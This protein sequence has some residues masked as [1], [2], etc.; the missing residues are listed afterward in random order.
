M[1]ENWANLSFGSK[2]GIVVG[3]T[4]VLCLFSFLLFNGIFVNTVDNYQVAYRY[5]LI[6]PNRGKIVILTNPDGS[7]RRGW[8]ITAPFVTKVHTVDLRPMQVQMNANSRVLNAKLIQF[9]P[10]GLKLFLDWHGRNNYEGPGS[11]GTTG[12]GV[13]ST[14]FSEILRSYAYDGKHYPFLTI[15]RE[16]KSETGDNPLDGEGKEIKFSPMPKDS[17]HQNGN[18]GG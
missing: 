9:N 1:N 2:F 13:G 17:S 5:D 14:V 18:L 8:V 11:P 10:D 12:G 16:L 6:G 15:L 7:Y 4:F 3:A